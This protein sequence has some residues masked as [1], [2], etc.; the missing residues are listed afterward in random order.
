[1]A[2]YYTLHATAA[3]Q[4]YQKGVD[5]HLIM[6][7]TRHSSESGVRCYFSDQQKVLSDLINANGPLPKAIKT[8]KFTV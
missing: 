2:E 8:V 4:L 3:S 1:M 5:E 6:E 7:R